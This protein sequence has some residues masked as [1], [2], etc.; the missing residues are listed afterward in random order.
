MGNTVSF[1]NVSVLVETPKALLVDIEGEE[2]WIPLSQIDD[3]SE[4][5]KANTCGRLVITEW[6]AKAKG[7]V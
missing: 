4:V 7:L 6:I 2:V 3:D 5:Y 1:E